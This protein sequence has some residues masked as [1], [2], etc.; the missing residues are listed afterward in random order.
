MPHADYC[1]YV[2]TMGLLF[3]SVRTSLRRNNMHNCS[4]VW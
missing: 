3:T 4:Q 1:N 2:T